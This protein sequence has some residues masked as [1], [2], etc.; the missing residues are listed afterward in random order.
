M[1]GEAL[2]AKL[3]HRPGRTQAE[4]QAR[5]HS[6]NP[7][8]CT[9]QHSAPRAANLCAGRC[10]EVERER[11]QAC[12]EFFTKRVVNQALTRDAG[13]PFESFRVHLQ[14]I[15]SFPTRARAGMTDVHAGLIRQHKVNGRETCAKL[16]FNARSAR[17]MRFVLC[18]FL[19]RLT[20]GAHTGLPNG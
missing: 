12:V 1:L 17:K 19:V 7:C 11:V 5:Y 10:F 2:A 16:R 14:V 20:S 15:V 8:Q 18:Q 4:H 3:Q 6:G 9:P 13:K